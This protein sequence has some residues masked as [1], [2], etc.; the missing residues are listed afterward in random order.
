MLKNEGISFL[1]Q[2]PHVSVQTF[3]LVPKPCPQPREECIFSVGPRP[4]LPLP[5]QPA[6]QD[7]SLLAGPPCTLLSGV[8]DALLLLSVFCGGA[9]SPCVFSRQARCV[10]PCP[11]ALALLSS[12]CV[13]RQVSPATLHQ[14][15]AVLCS[16]P[17][18]RVLPGSA[19]WPGDP[20]P[21][22]AMSQVR[23][24]ANT[25]SWG[26]GVC[27]GSS[28]HIHTQPTHPG[29]VIRWVPNED[30]ARVPYKAT[31][32]SHRQ[33]VLPLRGNSGSRQPS[34]LRAL[35]PSCH[36]A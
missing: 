16:L 27:L 18:S 2:T 12:Q 29:P 34:P 14:R 13:R 33:G 28:F 21:L 1:N 35:G 8:W 26:I 17:W 5:P 4:S 10:C 3:L 9:H 19:G 11:S 30:W 23:T 24:H 7:S 15:A 6:L 36:P 31:A 32:V 22:C 20:H 25:I